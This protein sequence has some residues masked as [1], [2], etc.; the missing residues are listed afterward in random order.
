MEKFSQAEA[1]NEDELT[2]PESVGRRNFL[3]G[4]FAAGVVAAVGGQP[5]RELFEETLTPEQTEKELT[6]CLEKLKSEYGVEIDFSELKDADKKIEHLSLAEQRDFAESMLGALEVYPKSYV[7]GSGLTTIKTGKHLRIESDNSKTSKTEAY[8]SS[9]YPERVLISKESFEGYL[10]DKFGWDNDRRMKSTFHHEFYHQNDPH[11]HDRAFNH[12]WTMEEATKGADPHFHTQDVF[13]I[14]RE[15]FAS[16]YGALGGAAED[17]AEVAAALLLDPE[18]FERI[19]LDEPA[20]VDKIQKIKKEFFDR[21]H[22]I[23]DETYW[24]LRSGGDMKAIKEYF[25][26]REQLSESSDK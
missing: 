7:H 15:G 1:N 21:S 24:K 19:A 26:L 13:S 16:T 10:T 18:A 2:Q 14:R 20:L 3:R 5:I 23:M 25:L 4:V 9:K 12:G 11:V 6:E 22:G 8:F 17:R